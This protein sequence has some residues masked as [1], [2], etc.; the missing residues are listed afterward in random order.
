MNTALKSE[1]AYANSPRYIQTQNGIIVDASQDIW[2]YQDKL[3]DIKL[4][5]LSLPVSEQIRESIKSTFVWF[6]ENDAPDYLRNL[7][8]YLSYLLKYIHSSS[9]N[10]V[11]EISLEML[12]SYHSSLIGDTR[13]HLSYIRNQCCPVKLPRITD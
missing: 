1:R 13:Y 2:K 10:T 12:I 9:G 8:T 7:L 3:V 6:A 11:S 5:F 4:D